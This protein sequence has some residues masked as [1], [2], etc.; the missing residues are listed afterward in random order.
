MLSLIIDINFLYFFRVGSNGQAQTACPAGNC[1][2]VTMFLSVTAV[3]LLL[4]LL[5]NIFK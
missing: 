4:V 5:Y 2:G 3:Q 1:V